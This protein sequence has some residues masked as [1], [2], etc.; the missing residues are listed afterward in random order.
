MLFRSEKPVLEKLSVEAAEA[1]IGLGVASM[2]RLGPGADD[3]GKQVYSFN[4][5]VA[6][7]VFDA[8]GRILLSKFDQLE[9][10]TPNYDGATMPHLSG[11]PG[12]TPYNN[13]SDHDAKIDGV[14][15]MTND[16]FLAEVESWQTKRERGEGYVMG[17]G[18]WAQQ[19]DTFERLFVGKT[20]EEVK[21][22]F[23]KY[24]SDRN[25]RP[26]KAGSSN[27]QDAAKFNALTAEE[28][29]MLADV[30]TSATMS[31]NDSHGNLLGAI[32]KAYEN[33]V[34]IELTIGK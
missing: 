26:L 12:Q 21:D 19:M 1:T 16:S 14:V 3:T 15:E 31:L 4:Q 10:A 29:A 5:V 23:A 9:V 11:F 18:Y 22:W 6:G 2:G 7:V 32:E 20:V 33:R 27:E 25:G 30:T 24:C 17:T 13:D 28:Q 8:E 34:E